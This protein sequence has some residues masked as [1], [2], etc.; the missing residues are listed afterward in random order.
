[1][2]PYDDDF[3]LNVIR[4][5]MTVISQDKNLVVKH[6]SGQHVTT[7]YF[8]T[9]ELFFTNKINLDGGGSEDHR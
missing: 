4:Q 9:V 5:H 2:A 7:L 6:I 1:M 8:T 3:I